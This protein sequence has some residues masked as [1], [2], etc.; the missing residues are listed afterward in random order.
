VLLGEATHGTQEFY[1]ARAAITKD[2][3]AKHGFEAVA[4]EADWPNSYRANQYVM[5]CGSRDANAQEALSGFCRFPRWMWMNTVVAEF[6][7]W[8]RE[9]NK[10]RQANR[11][12]GFY[13]LDLYSLTASRRAVI[14]Y[15]DKV[16]SG[17][18]ERARRRY[19]CFDHVGKDPQRYGLEVATGVRGRGKSGVVAQLVE[20]LRNT[21]EQLERYTTEGTEDHGSA[22]AFYAEQNARVVKNA[23]EYYTSMFDVSRESWN[24]RDTHMMETLE[25]LVGWIRV[26]DGGHGKVVVWAHNSHLGDCRATQMGRQGN[27]LN[28]GQLVREKWGKR[29]KNI[30]FTTYT[31]TVMAADDWGAPGKVKKV[32]PAR[33]DSFEWALNQRGESFFLPLARE[34]ACEE[35]EQD[36]GGEKL[37]RAIGVIYLPHIERTSHYFYAELTRQFDGVVHF[38]KTSALKPLEA[39]R[40]K[41][42]KAVEGELLEEE[43]IG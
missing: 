16:D 35:V 22:A 12:V 5:G 32:V 42:K 13:G 14:D 18:A 31:G 3:V 8:L 38:R 25:R 34:E 29:C 37:E 23:E 10:P 39:G 36:L 17:A 15:L 28:L 7:E 2:L 9:H 41:S 30:G 19:E 26:R 1:L 40:I 11:R 43:L 6:I 21:Q 24:V 27:Q 20:M 4:I 33:E